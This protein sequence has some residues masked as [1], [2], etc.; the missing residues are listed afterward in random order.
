M[1]AKQLPAIPTHP[2]PKQRWNV[3][4]TVN[5][6]RKPI[7]SRSTY[8]LYE[9]VRALVQVL[10]RVSYGSYKCSYE[11]RTSARTGSYNLY[12]D[13][14]ITDSPPFFTVLARISSLF[15]GG[16]DWHSWELFYRHSIAFVL[17]YLMF[18]SMVFKN[19]Y[20]GRTNFKSPKIRTTR[21]FRRI[22]SGKSMQKVCIDR[23]MSSRG[24]WGR[25]VVLGKSPRAAT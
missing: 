25:S 16:M 2:A 6:G 22:L 20:V 8:E 4:E 7:M 23:I 15:R 13:L 14:Y 1:V 12:V 17:T 19:S 9:P 21:K 10:V 11:Y 24:L 3:F 5:N 18:L